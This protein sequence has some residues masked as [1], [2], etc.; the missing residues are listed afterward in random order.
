MRTYVGG[1]G[2]VEDSVGMSSESC[3]LLHRWI[4][5]DTHY[6]DISSTSILEWRG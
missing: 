4:L 3:D 6:N 1:H 5:P 2:E